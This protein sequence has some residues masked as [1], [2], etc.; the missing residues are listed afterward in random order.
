MNELLQLWANAASFFA[1]AVARF[2]NIGGA[3]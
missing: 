1:Y 3:V 2:V